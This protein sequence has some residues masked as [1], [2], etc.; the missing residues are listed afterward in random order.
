MSIAQL[1][2]FLN[3]CVISIASVYETIFCIDTTF[4]IC[5]GLHLTDT[6]YPNL[7]LHDIS[8]KHPEFLGP[9]F[10]HFKRTWETYHCFAGES[11]MY[12]PLLINLHK[13]GH[14]LDKG[15][16]EG[17]NF[18]LIQFYLAWG[19]KINY[20]KGITCIEGKKII[21]KKSKM[22]K[23]SSSLLWAVCRKIKKFCGNKINRFANLTEIILAIINSLKMPSWTNY[24]QTSSHFSSFFPPQVKRN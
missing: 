12:K 23:L 8:G 21:T 13:I 11:L 15:L 1:T 20:S 3:N 7:S 17:I 9:S 22:G 14:D 4:E 5:D 2:S 10:W 16:A 24:L 18:W 6:T 19:A